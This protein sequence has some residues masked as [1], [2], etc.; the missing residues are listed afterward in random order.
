MIT[1][2]RHKNN[3][4]DCQ[5]IKKEE[6][7]F[8]GWL[9]KKERG[10]RVSMRDGLCMLASA[11]GFLTKDAYMVSWTNEEGTCVH[12]VCIITV[13]QMPCWY[14]VYFNHVYYIIQTNHH[15]FNSM[16]VSSMQKKGHL[17]HCIVM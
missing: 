9:Q 14:T 5:P 12:Y 3:K 17:V 1:K 2:P 13:F 11:L 6:Y 15:I 10:E 7:P 4:S 16:H 8:E